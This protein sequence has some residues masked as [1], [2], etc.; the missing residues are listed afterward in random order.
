VHHRE[1]EPISARWPSRLSSRR[2]R[3]FG[4]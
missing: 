3:A 4:S 1:F 2:C